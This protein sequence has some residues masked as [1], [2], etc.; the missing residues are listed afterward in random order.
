MVSYLLLRLEEELG[1]EV[2]REDGSDKDDVHNP[3][4]NAQRPFLVK[5]LRFGVLGF[6]T[7]FLGRGRKR[8][9]V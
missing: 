4:W 8:G 3:L 6:G 7:H 1:R 5:D 2:P 9:R